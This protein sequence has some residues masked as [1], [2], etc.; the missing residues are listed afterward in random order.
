MEIISIFQS[1]EL[2]YLPLTNKFFCITLGGCVEI[3][4]K[5]VPSSSFTA[6]SIFSLQLFGYWN[7]ILYR[8]SPLYVCIPTV[9]RSKCVSPLFRLTQDTWRIGMCS[10]SNSFCWIFYNILER[11]YCKMW[12]FKVNWTKWKEMFN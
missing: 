12:N 3:W 4:Q 8:V 1:S 7:S 9:S 6:D 2:F 5:Y 10:K 11:V